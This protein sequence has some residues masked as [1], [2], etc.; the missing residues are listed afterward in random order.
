MPWLRRW[1]WLPVI[2]APKF[3][4]PFVYA[5]DIANAVVGALKNDASA[6]QRYIT[7]GANATLF[8]LINAYKI[9]SGKSN[10]VWPLPLGGLGMYVDCSRAEREIGFAP[11]PFVDGMR[12]T[13]ADDRKYRAAGVG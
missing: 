8:D 13:I 7:A 2:V 11:R 12:E 5:G 3:W 1:M 9:A 4:F 10:L 6:G